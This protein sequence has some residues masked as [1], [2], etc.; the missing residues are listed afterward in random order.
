MANLTRY[1]LV[2]MRVGDR[3]V[4]KWMEE[5]G[6]GEYVK[7]DDIKELLNTSTNTQSTAVAQIAASI[8]GCIRFIERGLVNRAVDDLFNV[9]QQLRTLS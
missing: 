5:I 3:V 9:V 4:D 6:D 8:S 2:E 1:N 7:F